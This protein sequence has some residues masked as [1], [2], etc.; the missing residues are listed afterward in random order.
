[1]DGFSTFC[2][3]VEKVIGVQRFYVDADSLDDAKQM[4]VN[5]PN[6]AVFVNEDVVVSQVGP[7][8]WEDEV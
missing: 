3:T 4:M 5:N 1:M 2:S 6:S 8:E 7:V